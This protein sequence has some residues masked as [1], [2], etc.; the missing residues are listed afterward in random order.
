MFVSN[1]HQNF[2]FKHKSLSVVIALQI[3]ETW[4]RKLYKAYINHSKRHLAGRPVCVTYTYI[5]YCDTYLRQG[6]QNW[7][8]GNSGGL[9]QGSFASFSC[10]YLVFS[11]KRTPNNY[12]HFCSYVMYMYHQIHIMKARLIQSQFCDETNF[13][14]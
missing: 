10:L 2:P 12:S 4:I 7:V 11:A 9:L 1:M 8:F 6:Y 13:S 3:Y 14:S 5:S